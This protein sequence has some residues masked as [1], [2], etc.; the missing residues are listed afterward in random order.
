MK[1]T[2]EYGEWKG[3]ILRMAWMFLPSLGKW[4][5]YY[6][7]SLISKGMRPPEYSFLYRR[8]G[9]LEF[10]VTVEILWNEIFCINKHFI[11]FDASLC[12][13]Q[14][15]RL[16][17]AHKGIGKWSVCAACHL[18]KPEGNSPWGKGKLLT[19]INDKILTNQLVLDESK[20]A[21]LFVSICTFIVGVG[22]MM[23]ANSIWRANIALCK[24]S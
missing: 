5:R 1:R 12:N 14:L 17:N 24:S 13:L 18:A 19:D 15:S 6:P 23:A 8:P 9:S 4:W 3:T 20:W 11:R 10:L 7:Q 21:M 22:T 2:L 16:K